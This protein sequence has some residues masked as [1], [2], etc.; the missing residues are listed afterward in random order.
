[1]ENKIKDAREALMA[2]GFSNYEA[3]AYCALLTRSPANGYQVA[4]E[5]GIPRAKIYEC[6]QRLVNRGAAIQVE[7]TQSAQHF[8]GSLGADYTFSDAL[9]ASLTFGVDF[10][11]SV[12]SEFKPF[13]YDIDNFTGNDVDGAKSLNDRNAKQWVRCYLCRDRRRQA[14]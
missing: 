7:T 4:Q 3:K 11:N 14:H 6:L 8:T 13:G 5:S 2:L 9:N 1:M 10:V 12:A